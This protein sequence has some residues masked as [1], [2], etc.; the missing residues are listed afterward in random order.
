MRLR[1][2]AQFAPNW[3]SNID[4]LDGS[5]TSGWQH[6]DPHCRRLLACRSQIPI[7][8]QTCSVD[9]MREVPFCMLQAGHEAKEWRKASKRP[10]VY[11]NRLLLVQ[12]R[13]H[14]HAKHV[15]IPSFTKLCAGISAPPLLPGDPP[16][17]EG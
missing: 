3:Y 13:C 5:A 9:R 10:I 14:H 8:I 2:S 15:V 7:S 16:L 11:W 17:D 4:M 6:L 1:S 12:L